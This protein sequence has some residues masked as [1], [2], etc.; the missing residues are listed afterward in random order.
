MALAA[1]CGTTVPNATDRADLGS[2]GGL[3]PG[4]GG[5]AADGS[6]GS[7]T[8]PATGRDATGGTLSSTGQGGATGGQGGAAQGP[9]SGAGSGATAVG[10]VSKSRPVKVG[11]LLT[12]VGQASALGLSV[13]NT[14]S[15]REFD[16]AVIKAMNQHGGIQGHQ[17]VPVYAE[18][19]TASSNWESDYQAACATFTQDDRVDAVLGSSFAYFA[20]FEACLTKAGI[21]HLT[22]S[23]N[24]ADNQELSRYPLLRALIVPTID[25]R[26]IAKLQGA[27]NTGFL[28]PHNKLGVITDSCPGSQRAW[29]DVVKP[30]L[31]RNHIT[32]AKTADEGCANGN[33]ESFS[34]AGAAVSDALLSFR[35]A[36][37][38][39]ITFITVSE[40]GTMLVMTQGAS[41][42]KYY[43]GW[44]VS[45]LVGTSILQGQAPA[46]QMKNTRVYGWLPSQDVT[47]GYY[48]KPNAAQRRCYGYLKTAHITPVSPADYSYTQSICEALF[49]YEAAIHAT[50]G[51][52]NGG[53]VV[54]ALDGL[55]SSLQSVF[56]LRGATH[57]SPDKHNDVPALYREAAWVDGCSCFQYR[58]PAYPM[59]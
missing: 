32:I 27:I 8:S 51:L 2:T 14:H 9:G 59:P 11:I 7:S 24:V 44:I 31:E 49:A 15:E 50:G 5:A 42:Q 10:G 45:S 21:P 34:S 54:Q 57:F 19:N 30:F 16:D 37:V 1:A 36:G 39:R 13:G 56:D 4:A 17:I 52:L 48:D 25:V 3:A 6:S 40:S 35:S 43:P 12:T 38:D 55:G 18:T 29:T 53:A 47:P 58:G 22:N 26:S 20:S 33:N 41:S 46:E 23:S 28:T